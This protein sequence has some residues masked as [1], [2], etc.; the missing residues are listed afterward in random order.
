MRTAN[1]PSD[2]D[3][4][5]ASLPAARREPKSERSRRQGEPP[6]GPLTV[7]KLGG[8]HAYAPEL[9]TWLKAI[10]R[11]R[12]S[13]VIV[14][15]GGPF[16]DAVRLA[17]KRMG[18]DDRAAHDMAMMAMAQFGR[19]LTSLEPTLRLAASRAAIRRALLDKMIPVWA[20][21]RMA[22]AA[23]LPESWELTSDSLAAWLAGEIG[24]TRLVLI[25]YC[26]SEGP[27]LNAEELATRGV[28]DP[29]FPRYLSLSG[30]RAYLAASDAAARFERESPRLAFPQI[31]TK[32]AAHGEA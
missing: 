1:V 11:A 32:E 15:G 27:T 13:A 7:F 19:A 24:A 31:V 5:N 3:A 25:K 30:A 4:H 22:A 29:L 9:R 2:S 16:A 26:Q 20:P 12:G 18:F 14:P 17:Q 6:R 28:V 21:E 23:S 8:S 10:A